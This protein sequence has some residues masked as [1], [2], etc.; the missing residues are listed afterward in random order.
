MV[1]TYDN[2]RTES[3]SFFYIAMTFD[4]ASTGSCLHVCYLWFIRMTSLVT[5]IFFFAINMTFDIPSTGNLWTNLKCPGKCVT[6]RVKVKS[7]L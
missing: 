3:C 4:I 6:G 5:A 2:L 1:H 7:C